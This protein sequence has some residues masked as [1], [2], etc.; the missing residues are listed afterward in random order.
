[1]HSHWYDTITTIHLQNSFHFTKQKLCTYFFERDQ[2]SSPLSTAPTLMDST[3][4][5]G[6][7]WPSQGLFFRHSPEPF[8]MGLQPPRLNSSLHGGLWDPHAADT[9]GQPHRIFTLGPPCPA[10]SCS[11]WFSLPLYLFINNYPQP[12]AII[13][14]LSVFVSLTTLDTS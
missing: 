13:S 9:A 11:S 1:M 8:L 7:C 12:L 2:H 3:T 5:K 6:S 4:I 14:L 10:P